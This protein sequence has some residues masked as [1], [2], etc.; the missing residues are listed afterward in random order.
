MVAESVPD[1]LGEDPFN[2]D[3]LHEDLKPYVQ[4][5]WLRHPFVISMPPILVNHANAFYEQK[6]KEMAK[7]VKAQDWYKIIIL[8]EKPYRL[9]VLDEMFTTGTM[10]EGQTRRHLA[11][12][13]SNIEA[14]HQYG[15]MPLDLFRAV[16]FT[17]DIEPKNR[18]RKD[19]HGSR[20]STVIPWKTATI[21]RGQRK[22]DPA[23]IS[24]TLDK[25]RGIW[26][27]NRLRREGE[28]GQLVTGLVRRADVLGYFTGRGEDEIVVDPEQVQDKVFE[29]VPTRISHP[30]EIALIEGMGN[31]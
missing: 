2:I 13:W 24:W 27:A 26:F 22:G 17:H 15:N 3:N 19:T 6:V 9:G 21:Y 31:G 29:D 18:L 20:P 23:G 1:W 30:L 12:V 4:D 11:W 16:G 7:A 25:D 8:H 5:G 28:T 10:T 14:P